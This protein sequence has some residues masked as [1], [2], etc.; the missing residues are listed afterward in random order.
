M[1]GFTAELLKDIIT[2]FYTPLAQVYR[3]ASI[4]DSL[5]DLQ[6]FI[7]DL[8]KTVEQ[9]ER[10]LS[11]YVLPYLDCQPNVSDKVIQE[12][13][14]RT[15]QAF[16]NLIQRHEQSFYHFVHKV[17]SK[18]ENLFGGLMHWVELFLTVVREGLGSPLSLEFLL[19][20]TGK[21]R[22]NILNE[23][24]EVARYHYK[25]KVAY[26][27]KL[28]RRFG[29]IQERDGD[30][31]VEDEVTQNLV[32]GVI[33]EIDFGELIHG[34]ADDL[35]AE[36]TDEESSD[37]DDDS[38]EFESTD[39][40]CS[41]ESD[42]EDSNDEERS[43]PL[44][45]RQS[46]NHATTLPKRSQMLVAKPAELQPIPVTRDEAPRKRSL[47]LNSKSM[48]RPRQ[49]LPSMPSLSSL[50][51]S[52]TVDKFSKPVPLDPRVRPHE[53]TQTPVAP[54]Q[55]NQRQQS[56]FHSDQ[57]A[58]P[59][60][61]KFSLSASQGSKKRKGMSALKP[62]ELQHIPT[63]LPVFVEMV[64]FSFIDLDKRSST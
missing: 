6:S 25:L 50:P 52:A 17:H 21:D 29:R 33:G 61:S 31:E 40:S 53:Y 37:D 5:S 7:N 60:S 64:K 26:E 57:P 24:D 32:N 41:G 39:G 20:H 16:I 59:R 12:D 19:P 58:K 4:A 38:S 35:A 42:L 34:D 10:M 30:A 46:H 18:G 22:D 28:R 54:S 9:V 63:L 8:I 1:Q 62:P 51:K 23:V 43:L 47:S 14:S 3:A 44:P 49:D 13:S 36:E 11:F 15:V 27:A 45:S 48:P 56:T 2:I 55:S